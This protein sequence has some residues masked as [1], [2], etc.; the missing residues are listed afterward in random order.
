MFLAG[1]MISPTLISMVNLIELR[2]P[3]SRLTEALTWTGTGMAVGVA[4]GAAVA[5]WVVDG[6]GASAGFLV[7]LVAGM[8]ASVVAW[9]FHPDTESAVG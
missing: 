3:R 7:P 9:T 1:V 5:G 6:H 2:V 4:P 8:V